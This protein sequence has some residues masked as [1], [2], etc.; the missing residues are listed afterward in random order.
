MIKILAYI[1]LFIAIFNSVGSFIFA[2]NEKES[3]EKKDKNYYRA[4]FVEYFF[5]AIWLYSL[6]KI[7]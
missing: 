4:N 5:I 1:F 3:Y 6:L 2:L 7:L